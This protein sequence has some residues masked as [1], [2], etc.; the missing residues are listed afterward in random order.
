MLATRIP[1]LDSMKLGDRIKDLRKKMGLTQEEMAARLKLSRPYVWQLENG[2]KPGGPKL[3]TDVEM[4]EKAHA[5]RTSP[6]PPGDIMRDVKITLP[7]YVPLLSMAQAGSVLVSWENLPAEWFDRVATDMDDPHAFA[8]EIRGD[9]AEPY[10]YDREKVIVL[11]S[12]TP[13]NSDLVVARFRN[14]DTVLKLYHETDGGRTVD[15][16]S[17]NTKYPPQS[18]RRSE[19]EAIAPVHSAI[20]RMRHGKP[21][22]NPVSVISRRPQGRPFA[23][24]VLGS[25]NSLAL[26]VN[27]L[28]K[29]SRGVPNI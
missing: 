3:Q 28:R 6:T 26:G 19:F 20:K 22:N 15:L 10:L 27:S 23:L 1:D 17:W 4:M 29:A 25:C 18:Y 13:W 5:E 21:Q 14:G 2:T 24:E 7:R 16:A 8:V 11:P 9:S 12:H